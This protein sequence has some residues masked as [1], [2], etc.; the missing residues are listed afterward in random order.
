MR[1]L[2]QIVLSVLVLAATL[3]LW[4]GYVPSAAAFLDRVGLADVLGLE[5]ADA[6]AA[7]GGRGFG[8]R[9]PAQVVVAEV[10]EGAMN[11]R[12]EAIGDGRALRSATLRTEVGGE[13]VEVALDTGGYVEAGTVIL[14]L[15]DEAER[16]A[17]ERARLMLADA[18]DDAERVGRLQDTGSVTEVRLREARL[19]LRTAELELQ[20]AEYE[21]ERR[22]IRAPFAGWVGLIDVAIG[23]R[24]SASDEVATLTDRSEIL[25]DFRV[26]ERAVSLVEPGMPLEARP[27]G[28]SGAPLPGEVHA[29]D[30][31][32][33]R[34]SRTLRVQ[35]RLANDD[36]RLRAGMAF[37]V[38]LRFPGETMAAVDPLAVQWAAEGSYVWAVREGAAQRVAVTIRQR[39]AGRVLVEGDLAPGDT[40]VV[41]G[42]QS[43]RPGAEVMVAN[44]AEA[45]AE[46]PVAGTSPRADPL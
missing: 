16:I 19:A 31:V 29:V 45:R 32:I 22:T 18:R 20:E 33:D 25:I 36:D 44:R 24:L 14:R 8:S 37:A 42:V 27:L 28:I 23:D 21:L 4:V 11:D 39:D 40:V 7:P 13:V 9:G 46:A 43:L 10:T 3:W 1:I 6:E 12:V 38:A 34:A 35:G 30:N 41:E 26:P 15:E 17:L 5:I 2:K